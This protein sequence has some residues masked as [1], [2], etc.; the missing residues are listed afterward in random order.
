MVLAVMGATSRNFIRGI[1]SYHIL[2][3]IGFMVLAIGFFTPY[4]FAA[5][6]S[7][8]IHHIVVKSSL[9]LIGGVA[10][11]LNKTDHLDKTATSGS[12]QRGW[13]S[14]FCFRRCRW[15]DCRPGADSGAN[16]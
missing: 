8:V 15:R 5:A 4:S 9:F 12:G 10:L 14:C 7:Y 3:Q 2:S 16:T 6:S 13:E 11:C 1:K